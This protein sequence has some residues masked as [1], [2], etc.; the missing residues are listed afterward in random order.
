MT[1]DFRPT[2]GGVPEKFPIFGRY[3]FLKPVSD[4]EGRALHAMFYSDL[5]YAE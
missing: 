1:Y 5:P 4:E 2:K 3:L